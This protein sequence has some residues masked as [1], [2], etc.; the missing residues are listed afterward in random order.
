V[1]P[2]NYS[3]T[4]IETVPA[5]AALAKRTV[6][7]TAGDFGSLDFCDSP[8][9]FSRKSSYVRFNIDNRC[10]A[11]LNLSVLLLDK[12]GKYKDAVLRNY[13]FNNTT[14]RVEGIPVKESFILSPEE[15]IVE[16]LRSM[17]GASGDASGELGKNKLSFIL[18]LDRNKDRIYEENAT[19]N[20][21]VRSIRQDEIYIMQKE[22]GKF[23]DMLEYE[24]VIYDKWVNET[25]D[26][27]NITRLMDW[28]RTNPP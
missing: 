17:S 28:K 5:M 2:G 3:V 26:G 6:T 27:K 13:L 9:T 12:D 10:N 14:R 4:C 25:V 23:E 8:A 7:A 16:L 11:S 24:L 21:S 1:E 22:K 19:L 20:V 18:K 15:S